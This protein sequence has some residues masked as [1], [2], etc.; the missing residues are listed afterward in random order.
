[1]SWA[2]D[3]RDMGIISVDEYD[4]IKEL[5]WELRHYGD[6]E[7]LQKLWEIAYRYG[8]DE[9]GDRFL[10][11]WLEAIDFYESIYDYKIQYDPVCLRWRSTVNDDIYFRKTGEWISA[12]KGQFFPDPYEWIRY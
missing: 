7:A 10:E 2:R 9:L 6:V 1:M 3:L 4:E 11:E 8:L 12:K 5:G